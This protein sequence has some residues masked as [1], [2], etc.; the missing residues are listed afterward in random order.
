ML[1]QKNVQILSYI[2]DCTIDGKTAGIAEIAALAGISTRMVRYNLNQIDDYLQENGFSKLIRKRTGGVCLDS[3]KDVL[4]RL[5]AQMT[6][7]Q[8]SIYILNRRERELYLLLELFMLDAP[9]RYEDLADQLCVSRKTVIEDIRHVRESETDT[10]FDIEP[11]KYGIQ[12]MGTEGCIRSILMR[13]MLELY[14]IS[15]IWLIFSGGALN[16]SIPVENRVA[17]LVSG[18][19]ASTIERSLRFAEAN[20]E[21]Q[22]SDDMF[23]LLASL[24]MFSVCRIQ[25]GKQIGE[26]I[27]GYVAEDINSFAEHIQQETGYVLP[28]SERAFWMT[29][30]NKLMNDSRTEQAENMSMIVTESLISE[31]SRCDGYD[32][33]RDDALRSDLHRHLFLLI[34]NKMQRKNLDGVTTAAILQENGHLAKCIQKCLVSLTG[35]DEM[36][37]DERES[38]LIVLHFLASKERRN[39]KT[40]RPCKVLV[41]CAN[42][43]GSARLVSAKLKNNFPQ[44][45]IMD[46][47]SIHNVDR[48]IEGNRPDLIITTIRLT[49]KQ[50]PT[51]RVNPILTQ[52]DVDRVRSF[53]IEFSFETETESFQERRYNEILS[54]IESTCR[55]DNARDL[56]R[57]LHKI[58][59]IG[60]EPRRNQREPRLSDVLKAEYVRLEIEAENWMEAVRK[61]AEPLV[62]NNCITDEYVEAMIRNISENGPYI[63][64]APGIALPHAL[65]KFGVLRSC[66][67]IGVL[68]HSVRFGHETND[69]VRILICL[70]TVDGHEHMKTIASLLNVVS[71]EGFMNHAQCAKSGQEILKLINNIQANNRR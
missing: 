61:S 36:V 24:G 52:E 40:L 34:K 19:D 67:S 42:G 14:T 58:L 48:I 15:E 46:V 4:D 71:D 38:A 6:T 45:Q 53:I 54:L 20:D 69:P 5:Q 33:F 41:V 16:K 66:V 59:G 7:V 65:P 37:C 63:V 18:I 64:I 50:I 57:G 60:S 11:G 22:Y 51:L 49:D 70:G 30:L 28:Y 55:I 2:Y 56:D 9:V 12:Y 27:Q 62:Q 1:S 10:D 25:R 44:L 68:K 8:N 31:V 3:E 13:R 29:E 39:L 47:T 21:K 17:E 32:Y 23:Y 43:I 26:A 35:L